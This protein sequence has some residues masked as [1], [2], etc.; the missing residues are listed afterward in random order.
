MT[1]TLPILTSTRL[2][3]SIYFLALGSFAI[4]TEG[5]MVSGLLPV[6]ATDLSVSISEAGLLV[7]AFALAYAFS[8]PILNTLLAGADRRRLL[9]GALMCFAL[10]NFAACFAPGYR[11]LLVARVF[12][13]FAAGIYMPSASAL[14]SSLVPTESRGRALATVHGGITLALAVGVP[15]GSLIGAG[16]G[17][18]ATFGCVGAIAAVVTIGVAR[19]LH[20]PHQLVVPSMTERLAVVRQPQV[21]ISFLVTTL[22]ATGIWTIYPYIATL[23][24][25]GA[26]ITGKTLSVVLLWYGLCAAV[27]V[28]VSSRAV[29]RF[30]YD[31]VLVIGVLVLVVTY[32]SLSLSPLLLTQPASTVAI[33]LAIGVWGVAGFTFNSAQQAKLVD[34]LGQKVAPVS[35][36]LNSSFVYLGFALGALLGSL[37]IEFG[38]VRNIGFAGSLCELLAVLLMFHQSRAAR[39]SLIP[40]HNITDTS[41]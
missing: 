1:Q 40:Q 35:L 41:T 8:S 5:F 32:A 14:A 17:W 28:F 7:T 18:R 15:F 37:L 38:S 4:G 13:A 23:L 36:S 39:P 3:S 9:I 16:L 34:I 25:D 29:D 30:G 19:G 20:A 24:A 2:P 22:W 26:G 31:R 6:I 11:S 10:I 33:V 21:L 27:G 12:L